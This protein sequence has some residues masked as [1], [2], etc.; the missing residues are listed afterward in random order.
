[1]IRLLRSYCKDVYRTKWNLRCKNGI[2]TVSHELK[3]SVKRKKLLK[4]TKLKWWKSKKIN[5]RDQHY[6][7]IG[8]RKESVN[9]TINQ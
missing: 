7:W 5:M 1:M 9:L 6:I 3:K 4:R 8:K 2:I